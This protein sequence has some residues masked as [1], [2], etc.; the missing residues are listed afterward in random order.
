MPTTRTNSV[1]VP[2]SI[3]PVRAHDV[4]TFFY[5]CMQAAQRVLE[6]F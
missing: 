6:T 2:F 3:L 5:D 4:G 1:S